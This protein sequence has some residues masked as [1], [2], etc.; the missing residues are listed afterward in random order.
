MKFCLAPPLCCVVTCIVCLWRPAILPNP[1][2]QYNEVG[3]HADDPGRLAFRHENDGESAVTASILPYSP[4]PS[5]S[6]MPW[7]DNLHT[8]Y[9]GKEEDGDQNI[10]LRM[11]DLDKVIIPAA[12]P[13]PP[14][15]QLTSTSPIPGKAIKDTRPPAKVLSDAFKIP[16][17]HY[18]L[19]QEQLAP[20]VKKVTLMEQ[21][22][23]QAPVVDSHKMRI[24]ELLG[25]LNVA[26][27]E[28]KALMPGSFTLVAGLSSYTLL[29]FVFFLLSFFL[30]LSS[31]Q[32]VVVYVCMMRL[33]QYVPPQLIL[34]VQTTDYSFNFL[35]T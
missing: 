29:L 23:K 1:V 11:L 34:M 28:M 15:P 32:V 17:P 8:A 3:D 6:E 9:S 5:P 24:A 35:T 33:V 2:T 20:K 26:E 16:T 12:K 21:A 13:K 7:K 27:R 18:F 25:K 14:E 31:N 10:S 22:I 4:P 19:P 30:E